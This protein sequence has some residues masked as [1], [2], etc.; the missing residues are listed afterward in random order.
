[1][2]LDRALI[3]LGLLSF[4]AAALACGWGQGWAQFG[5]VVLIL[6]LMEFL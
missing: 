3:S 1:M 5:A 2:K 4:I 6:V